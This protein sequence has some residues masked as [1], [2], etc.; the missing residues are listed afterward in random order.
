MNPEL[1]VKMM[2][3]PRSGKVL[4]YIKRFSDAGIKINAQLVLCPEVND[5][6]ELVFSLN[7]LAKY[8]P[9]V[10]SISAVP[11]GLTKFR[12]KLYPLRA[13]TKE[14]A[15]AVI[16]TVEEFNDRLISEGKERLAFAADEFYI[17]A[18]RE[19]PKAEYYGEF[20][21]LENGV[22]MWAL[23]K[24]EFLEALEN[25]ETDSLPSP[26]KVSIA[27]GVAAYPLIR[28]LCDKAESRIKGLKADVFCVLNDFFGHTITVSGLVTG[29][30]IIK[31][32][33]GKVTGTLLLPANMFK[34]KDELIFLDDVT[35][36]EL[37][38]ELGAE[39][40]VIDNNGFDFLDAL[41]N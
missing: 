18:E 12:E 8:Y 22:G 27:T 20:H 16:D 26:K 33:K 29:Q 24:S 6:D 37:E 35:K 3:N 31:Q 4:Q 19:I 21:Q 17:K 13:F 9:Q 7:E 28:E 2:K 39:I 40:K 32:L 38:K 15:A 5:G 1:R 23:F 10:Q 36:E 41:I 14:E 34:S 30:D 25:L 11:V